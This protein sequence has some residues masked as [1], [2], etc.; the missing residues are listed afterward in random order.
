M[1][2]SAYLKID[3]AVKHINDLN[4]AAVS[5]SNQSQPV[6][7]NSDPEAGTHSIQYE[8]DFI[9]P[10]IGLIIGDAV[11]NL[12]S[13]LDHAYSAAVGAQEVMTGQVFF[14]IRDNRASTV[15]AL[16]KAMKN[17]HTVPKPLYDCILDEIRPYDGGNA[18]IVGLNKLSNRDKHR[19]TTVVAGVAS[20][21]LSYQ[22]G[23]INVDNAIF[24]APVGKTFKITTGPGVIK[25]Y[26]KPEVTLEIIFG[27]IGIT[28][29]QARSVIRTLFRLTETVNISVDMIAKA[30]SS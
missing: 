30:M 10:T 3:R 1:F 7:I 21:R 27:E 5:L 29:L 24:S 12:R 22:H 17:G 11:T 9:P 23:I 14:P 19:I 16:Q 4:D 8:S 28:Y 20:V 13:A 18:D 2:Q 26:K 15:G 25:F 6:T